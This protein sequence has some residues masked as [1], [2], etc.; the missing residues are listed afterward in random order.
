MSRGSRTLTALYSLTALWLSFCTYQTAGDVPFWSTCFMLAAGLIPIVA[1]V[2]EVDITELREQAGVRTAHRN[3]HA[4]AVAR[5][6]LDA[7]CCERWWTSF[8]TDHDPECEHQT[9]RSNAA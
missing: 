4:E 3:E 5:A 8:G 1:V 7:A 2:R 6:E 9:P